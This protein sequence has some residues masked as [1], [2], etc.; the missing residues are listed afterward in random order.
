MA[1]LKRT[2]AADVEAKVAEIA[3]GYVESTQRAREDLERAAAEARAVLQRD[4][5]GVKALTSQAVAAGVVVLDRCGGYT[6]YVS[7][8]HEGRRHVLVQGEGLPT[9]LGP[10]AVLAFVVPL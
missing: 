10:V 2:T 7:L 9:A 5:L 4:I 1:D 3:Q 6:P 8:E